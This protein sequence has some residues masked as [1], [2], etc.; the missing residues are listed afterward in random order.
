[1]QRVVIMMVMI[2]TG[3]GLGISAALADTLNGI[4]RLMSNSIY[5][6]DQNTVPSN[7]Q[8][9]YIRPLVEAPKAGSIEIIIHPETLAWTLPLIYE[10]FIR[11]S[12]EF[13]WRTISYIILRNSGQEEQAKVISVPI[14]D[15]LKHRDELDSKRLTEERQ[16]NERREKRLQKLAT[17]SKTACANTV[18]PIGQNAQQL[19]LPYNDDQTIVDEEGASIIRI[20]AEESIGEVTKYKVMVDG[21]TVHTKKLSLIVEGFPDKYIKADVIDESIY[22]ANNLYANALGKEIQI[23][24]LARPIMKDGEI[25]RLEVY[26]AW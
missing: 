9:P 20:K 14:L 3:L 12:S 22:E 26:S 13:L 21:V 16:I 19:I 5:L 10:P 7:R 4:S 15:Y 2:M 25:I 1:M 8:T 17:V 11:H 18:A 23:T 24:V 6:L